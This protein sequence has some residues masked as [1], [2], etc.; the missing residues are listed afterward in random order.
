MG[1]YLIQWSRQSRNISI[2]QR[3]DAE[4]CYTQ[5]FFLKAYVLNFSTTLNL[6]VEY[7]QGKIIKGPIFIKNKNTTFASTCYFP[8]RVLSS[9]I[10]VV[11]HIYNHKILLFSFINEDTKTQSLR[12]RIVLNFFKCYLFFK[13]QNLKPFLFDS[14]SHI[15]N[16][17]AILLFYFRS[18]AISL[19]PYCL[20]LL[21][22]YFLSCFGFGALK[23]DSKTRLSLS[24]LA[25]ILLLTVPKVSPYTFS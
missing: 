13:R 1:H 8:G 23:K 25:T 6:T 15:L 21:V 14:K 19:I 18:A 24:S 20:T 7:Y 11:F 16:N 4:R 9:A 17:F 5:V 3:K 12:G 10:T 22:T 2:L